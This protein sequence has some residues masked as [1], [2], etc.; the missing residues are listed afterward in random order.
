VGLPNP[1]LVRIEIVLFSSMQQVGGFKKFHPSGRERCGVIWANESSRW[2]Y[3]VLTSR[4]MNE[5]EFKGYGG[6]GFT[7]RV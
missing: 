7:F 1:S 5:P 4:L 2:G 3:L 6:L